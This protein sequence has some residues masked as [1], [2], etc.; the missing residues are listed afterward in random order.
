MGIAK[1][2]SHKALT[3]VTNGDLTGRLADHLIHC[4]WESSP[5][6][7]HTP[8]GTANITAN[9]AGRR[10]V[11]KESTVIVSGLM[12]PVNHLYREIIG[13]S[14]LLDKVVSGP[15]AP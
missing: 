1:K 8:L 10:A 6:R 15:S 7:N 3:R 11:F 12:G 14:S 5:L 9:T 2:L 4:E 13:P